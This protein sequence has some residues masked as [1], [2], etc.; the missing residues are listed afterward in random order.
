MSTTRTTNYIKNNKN[1]RRA[2][3]S[4]SSHAFKS[5]SKQSETDPPSRVQQAVDALRK[6]ILSIS[7]DNHFLGS[8]DRLIATLGV[9]RPTFRQAARLLEHEQLL[10]I[11][12]GIGGG[13]FTR[14]PSAAVVSRLASSFLNAQGTTLLQLNDATGPVLIEAVGLLARN[15]NPAVRTRLIEF[16]NEHAGFEESD[17]E[18]LHVKTILEF[19]QLIGQLCGNPALELMINV[20]RDLVRNPRHGY[21][22]IDRK[23]ARV[24]SEFSRRLARSV[25]DGDAEM[26]MLIVKR[27]VEDIRAWLPIAPTA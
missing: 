1:L 20:M 6:R 11:K 4:Q 16:V 26:A 8:E 21:F 5:K 14:A 12:R 7:Q 18:R 23:R 25:A 10:K 2:S 27:H 17:D 19:E 15:S 13:F 9:S 22:R 24:Y 3:S